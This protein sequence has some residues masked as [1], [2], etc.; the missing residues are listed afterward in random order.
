MNVSGDTTS[1]GK[2]EK[3]KIQ[4][5]LEARCL[6]RLVEGLS[7]LEEAQSAVAPNLAVY[8]SQQP[9]E[10][11]S[12]AYLAIEGIEEIKVHSPSR[13]MYREL[14]KEEQNQFRDLLKKITELESLYIPSRYDEEV[15]GKIRVP[16]L[17]FGQEEKEQSIRVARSCQKFCI[18]LIQ[19]RLGRKLPG[20][21]GKLLNELKGKY[22][23]VINLE[24]GEV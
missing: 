17:E 6:S 20:E 3:G 22:S 14:S 16:A 7:H 21:K 24:E 4:R 18:N 23:D 11:F 5:K 8:H 15:E 1:S 10:F 9:C 19:S 12:K 13:R 2:E